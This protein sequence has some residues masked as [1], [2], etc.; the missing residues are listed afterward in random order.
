MQRGQICN[1]NQKLKAIQLLFD[2]NRQQHAAV[3]T[4]QYPQHRGWHTSCQQHSETAIGNG[5]IAHCEAARG[6]GAIST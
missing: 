5:E 3:S 4:Y 6:R 2:D 1:N